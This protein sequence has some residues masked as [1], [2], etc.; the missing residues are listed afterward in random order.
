MPPAVWKV[1][2]AAPSA[3]KFYHSEIKGKHHWFRLAGT[4]AP[5]LTVAAPLPLN[6]PRTIVLGH[7]NRR[8]EL[9]DEMIRVVLSMFASVWPICGARASFS[10]RASSAPSHR[11]EPFCP[12]QTRP[13]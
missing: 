11:A 2:K 9:N 4:S 5:V 3:D 12:R 1:F 10:R 6:Q 8:R 7:T 13:G